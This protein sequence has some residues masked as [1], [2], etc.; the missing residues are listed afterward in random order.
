MPEP[1]APAITDDRVV[2]DFIVDLSTAGADCRA[3]L[4][5]VKNLKP[6]VNQ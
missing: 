6:V 3:K 2:A 1:L 5:T 4:E